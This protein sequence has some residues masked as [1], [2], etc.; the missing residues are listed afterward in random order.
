[1]WVCLDRLSFTCRVKASEVRAFDRWL[2]WSDYVSDLRRSMT[3]TFRQ[4]ATFAGCGVVEIGDRASGAGGNGLKLRFD[5]NPQKVPAL[6]LRE[7]ARF[8]H[9]DSIEFTRVDVAIDY[10]A[11]LGTCSC[12]HDS[13]RKVATY[14]NGADCTGWTF[15]SRKGSRY[16]R[17]YDK[18]RERE[19]RG[20]E[21]DAILAEVDGPLWRV[22]AEC[23]PHGGELLPEGLFDGLHLRDLLPELNLG[24][25]EFA[26]IQCCLA[27]PTFL[28]QI[29]TADGT[30]KRY[31][32]R[33]A[34]LTAE[35]D[36]SPASV[37]RDYRAD[38]LFQLSLVKLRMAGGRV[39]VKE[40][41]P[42]GEAATVLGESGIGKI[43]PHPEYTQARLPVSLATATI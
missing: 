29:P 3:P 26:V 31:K 14:G 43:A 7:L 19:E 40:G 39:E 35:L 6:A 18:R 5:F 20:F 8:V 25:R 10:N 11:A 1:V 24:W 4:G 38:L 23:R 28:R 36:P 37:Y 41:P 9:A 30:R 15:G 22:E 13:L 27:D 16:T 34:E 21:D 2:K 42:Q 33:L 32:E 12:T 17:V